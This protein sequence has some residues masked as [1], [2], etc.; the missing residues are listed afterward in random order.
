MT[1]PTGHPEQEAVIER[2]PGGVTFWVG[3]VFGALLV[4][5]GL[6]LTLTSNANWL[7]NLAAWFVA[8]GVLVDLVVVP[9]VGI[10]GLAGR[11]VL[12]V[13]AWRVVRAA[14]LVTA[15]LVV[16]SLVLLFNPGGRPGNPTVRSR[17]FG[18]GLVVYLAVV[19]VA[20]GVALVGS[21][22]VDRRGPTTTR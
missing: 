3:M 9:V 16:Y 10:V 1:H 22:Y 13:W 2:S 17:D 11:R 8:G 4:A 21:R 19:W 5:Y 7:K 12:P 20:A 15:L 6:R 14:L 18:N